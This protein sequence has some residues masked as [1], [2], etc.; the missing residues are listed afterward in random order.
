M[1]KTAILLI[2]SIAS[3]FSMQIYSQEVNL[4]YRPF[5]S[6]DGDT[7]AFLEYNFIDRGETAYQGITIEKLLDCYMVL[8]CNPIFIG[9]SL[10]TGGGEPARL[11]GLNIFPKYEEIPLPYSVDIEKKEFKLDIPIPDRKRRGSKAY[12]EVGVYPYL[13]SRDISK[14]KSEKQ[15]LFKKQT[16]SKVRLKGWL[17]EERIAQRKLQQK[18]EREEK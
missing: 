12:L 6:F 5:E 9:G 1:K 14:K 11:T 10:I 8:D 4:P 3:I 7:I 13:I 16:I 18:K 15:E 2:L 17:I